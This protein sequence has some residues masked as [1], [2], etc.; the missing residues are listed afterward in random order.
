MWKQTFP[1]DEEVEHIF[2]KRKKDA[3]K[4]KKELI[5]LTDEMI[6]EIEKCLPTWKIAAVECDI[7]IENK[8]EYED[9]LDEV[10]SGDIKMNMDFDNSTILSNAKEFLQK[11]TQILAPTSKVVE[12]I[13]RKMPSFDLLDFEREV[14]VRNNLIL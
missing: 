10:I 11:N 1:N 2:E 3:I 5:D 6:E 14:D 4:F 13:Q 12:I 8:G 9:G 7:V